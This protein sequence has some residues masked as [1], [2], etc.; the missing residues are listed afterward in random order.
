MK[1]QCRVVLLVVAVVGSICWSGCSTG[2]PINPGTGIVDIRVWCVLGFGETRGNRQNNGCR[3]TTTEMTDIVRQVQNSANVF[4]TNTQFRWQSAIADVESLYVSSNTGRT[5]DHTLL[6]DD[7][8]INDLSGTPIHDSFTINIY[9]GGNYMVDGGI[10][11]GG[12]FD[13]AAGVNYPLIIIND[14]GFAGL[15]AN[16]PVLLQRLT[17]PHEMAHYL[18]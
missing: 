18:G 4:G 15:G 12:T 5:Y 1:T 8:F 7:I 16:A 17:G 14:A 9:F 13:P 2:T 10:F 3:L 6:L 11:F